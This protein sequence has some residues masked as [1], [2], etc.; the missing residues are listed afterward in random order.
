[1]K[2][3]PATKQRIVD[4]RIGSRYRITDP[5]HPQAGKSGTLEFL[6]GGAVWLRI[7]GEDVAA[8]VEQLET[9]PPLTLMEKSQ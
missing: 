7:N 8:K 9:T 5:A 3:M 2:P 4:A 6:V 1:M